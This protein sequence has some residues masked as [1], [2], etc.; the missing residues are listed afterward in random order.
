MMMMIMIMIIVMMIMIMIIVMMIMI[1]MIVIMMIMSLVDMNMS[2]W[3]DGKINKDAI[4]VA[5]MYSSSR[6]AFNNYT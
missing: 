3:E 6:A 2:G 1:M 4:G 5:Y